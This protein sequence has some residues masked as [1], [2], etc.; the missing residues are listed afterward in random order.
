MVL[1]FLHDKK[2]TPVS[3]RRKAEEL[4]ARSVDASQSSKGSYL[5]GE[6]RL[7]R[8]GTEGDF[9]QFREYQIGDRPQDIDWKRSARSDDTLVREREK[10]QQ[11]IIDLYIQNYPGM[12]FGTKYETAA[13]LG[14]AFAL[15]AAH[16]HDPVRFWGRA[17]KIDDL[18]HLMLEQ[19]SAPPFTEWQKNSVTVLIGDYTDRIEDLSTTLFDLS[20]GNVIL[21]QVLSPEELDLPYHGRHVFEDEDTKTIINNTDSIRTDY[22]FA[23]QSHIQSLKDYCRKRNWHYDL[24]RTDQDIVPAFNRALASIGEKP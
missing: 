18:P 15:W 7:R 10:N 8:A 16:K 17:V 1:S 20:A 3:L 12:H 11:R 9:R 13:T 14:L 19:K 21:L 2:E 23:L 5:S 24:I 22:Q 4:L 6:N